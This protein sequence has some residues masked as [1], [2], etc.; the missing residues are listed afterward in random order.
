VPTATCA[1]NENSTV[2][3]GLQ[4]AGV[5]G[6]S[7]TFASGVLSVCVAGLPGTLAIQ[8][9]GDT[10]TPVMGVQPGDKVV[11]TFDHVKGTETLKDVTANLSGSIDIPDVSNQAG[12]FFGAHP[13]NPEVPMFDGGKVTL[14]VTVDGGTLAA[15]S[16]IKQ[17][18]RIGGISLA[19][20]AISAKS[21]KAFTI[22]EVDHN[23]A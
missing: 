18:K 7:T 16:P 15:A 11:L 19:P 6:S 9:N 13:A 5:S 2:F 8:Y 20:S 23:V 22:R 12:V 1:I 3:T 21:G 14:S 17:S 4:S 10:G